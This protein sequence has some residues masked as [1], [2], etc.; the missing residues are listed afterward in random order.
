M[1][2]GIPELSSYA[3][4]RVGQSKK[5]ANG[6]NAKNQKGP[7]LVEGCWGTPARQS[8]VSRG[9]CLSLFYGLWPEKN[10]PLHVVRGT[11]KGM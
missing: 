8:Q 2:T 6:R 3:H 4:R 5:K 9:R 7:G 10:V 11:T 1:N